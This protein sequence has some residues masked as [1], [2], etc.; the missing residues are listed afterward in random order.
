V[1]MYQSSLKNAIE[2]N[3]YTHTSFHCNGLAQTSTWDMS[4]VEWTWRLYYLLQP[5][6]PLKA[7]A[8]CL[9][10][11][12]EKF[13]NF[14]SRYSKLAFSKMYYFQGALDIVIAH[15][16]K[17]I[18]HDILCDMG[19]SDSTSDDSEDFENND[20]YALLEVSC[21]PDSD[22]DCSTEDDIVEISRYPSPISEL[23]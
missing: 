10:E 4:E 15:P 20:D 13:T 19:S 23:T 2:S 16:K 7:N 18:P 21:Y 3:G 8:S 6:M 14:Q 11:E 1:E 22:S 12:G 17:K 9:C 5:Y